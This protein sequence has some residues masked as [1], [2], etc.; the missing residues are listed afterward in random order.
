MLPIQDQEDIAAALPQHL[1]RFERFAD[2]GHGPW[3][4]Q[5]EKA[6]SVIREF[7]LS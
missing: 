5:P 4:D 2:C 6:F 1:V 3:R 7:I